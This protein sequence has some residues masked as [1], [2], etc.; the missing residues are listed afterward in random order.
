MITEPG[1]PQKKPLIYY[2]V[3]AMVVILLLNIFVFPAVV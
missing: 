3:V 2:Y 1:T